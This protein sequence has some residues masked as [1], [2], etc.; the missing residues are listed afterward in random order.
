[1]QVGFSKR[2]L[3]AGLILWLGS[4]LAAA[5]ADGP[6]ISLGHSTVPLNGPWSFALGDD[7]RWA[8]PTFDDGAW[9]RVDLTSASRATFPAG[10]IAA[11][12]DTSAT[13]GIA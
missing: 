9:E 7:P 11:I 3:L 12:A 10:T 2:A 8:S 13:P 6:A 1:M 5:T 4:A